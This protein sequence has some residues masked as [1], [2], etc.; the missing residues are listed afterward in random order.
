MTRTIVLFTLSV[1][2]LTA[3]GSATSSSFVE[4]TRNLTSMPLAFTANQGQWDEEVKFRANAGGATMW[5]AA[6]SAVVIG[7]DGVGKMGCA[8]N[9]RHIEALTD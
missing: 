9:R 5:F 3:S 8:V 4:V 7:G 1:I 2:L 6:E